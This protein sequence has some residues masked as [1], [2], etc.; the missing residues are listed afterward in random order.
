MRSG[1]LTSISS[2]QRGAVSSHLLPER[3]NFG[4]AV[5]MQLDRPIY[6]RRCKLRSLP[7]MPTKLGKLWSTN[8]EK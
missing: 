6:K 3:T 4:P 1:I 8:G 2:R 5:C 7:H